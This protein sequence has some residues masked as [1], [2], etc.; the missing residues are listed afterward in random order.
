MPAEPVPGPGTG[1]EPLPGGTSSPA[2]PGHSS[3]GPGQEGGPRHHLPHPGDGTRPGDDPA[4]T[5]DR[6]QDDILDMIIAGS[7]DEARR[8][9]KDDEEDWDGEDPD[10]S[11]PRA[12]IGVP[13][14]E[15]L[16]EAG[17]REAEQAPAPEAWGAGFLPREVRA[18]H[19]SPGPAGGFASGGPLDAAP[20]DP[21]VAAFAE[22]V[23]GPG[24]RCAGTTDDELIGVLRAWQ[25]Q[26]S[27]AAA[28]KLAVIAELIRRRPA[29]GCAPAGPGGM[30]RAW[31]KFCSDELAAATACSGQAAG[32]TLALAHD[33]A[34]RLPG[35]ARALHDGDIDL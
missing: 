17:A 8:L 12:Y 35:T 4:L 7:D 13:L 5:D 26:E 34:T 25:R 24:G 32:K 18:A 11:C 9:E 20:P 14:R 23:T 1:Q 10:S 27:R 31:G 15:I 22:D 19:P 3:G 16:A 21:V 30:P 6:A 28:R 33:L 29:P 2:G